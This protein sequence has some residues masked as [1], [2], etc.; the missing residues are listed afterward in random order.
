MI[1]DLQPENISTNYDTV[2]GF[3]VLAAMTIKSSVSFNVMWQ[4]FTNVLK[5]HRRTEPF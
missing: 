4:E 5:E 1:S 3:E 2:A